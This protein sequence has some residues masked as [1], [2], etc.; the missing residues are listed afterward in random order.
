MIIAFAVTDCESE[1]RNDGMVVLLAPALCRRRSLVITHSTA[2]QS[3]LNGR[4]SL[5]GWMATS[6][7]KSEF[8]RHHVITALRSFSW[9][10]VIL[11][12]SSPRIR[13]NRLN[14]THS[15]TR[16]AHHAPRKRF[17]SKPVRSLPPLLCS[18]SGVSEHPVAKLSKHCT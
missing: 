6:S 14:T 13:C 8:H 15:P 3:V 16:E 7:S 17:N 2:P 1:P 9:P 4:V 10:C 5:V 12:R 18:W 11:L